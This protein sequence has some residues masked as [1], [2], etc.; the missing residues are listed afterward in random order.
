MIERKPLRHQVQK[1]ILARLA[2]LR[3]APGTRI[4]ESHLSAELG[5]SRTPLREAM[6]GL[7][8]A[9]F[10][11]SDMGRGFVVPMLSSLEFT[12]AQAL[13]TRLAPYAL[14][15]SLPLPT[16]QIMEL[17][18]LLGRARLRAS[19]PGAQQATALAELVHRW[20]GLCLGG[21]QN[22]MLAGEVGRLEALSRRSWYAAVKSG[23]A[24]AEMVAGYGE[25]YEMLRGQQA[26]AAVA[27]WE[28]HLG[29]FAA[30]AARHL[31]APQ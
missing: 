20:S 26:Q 15:L 6:L 1:E 10:L 9:G 4:N 29:R 11:A 18:N 22:R 31:P 7:E 16:G 30:E 17:N 2:D 21:C 27:R 12:Q 19:E 5:I 25:L 8:A 3:L 28:H 24:P 23:F 13:L 14:S